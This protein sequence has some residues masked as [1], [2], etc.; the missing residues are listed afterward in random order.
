MA[1]GPRRLAK[2]IDGAAVFADATGVAG[3]MAGW[4]KVAG[5]DGAAGGDRVSVSMFGSNL[6][7]RL[8]RLS[9][10]LREGRYRPGPLRRVDIPK[11]DG[12]VR[13]LA[14]PCVADR[15]AQSSVA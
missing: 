14:I 11:P 15:V 1:S 3:L 12:G 13:G 4:R 7:Q 10:D 6:D 9:N 2:V 5:N 8:V